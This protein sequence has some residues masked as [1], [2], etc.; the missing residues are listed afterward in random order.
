[1]S[2]PTASTASATA[3]SLLPE[4]GCA[5]LDGIQDGMSMMYELVAR[6]GQLSASTGEI[7]VS[8]Q[9]RAQ[10]TQAQREEAAIKQEEAD[11]AKLDTGGGLFGAICHIFSDIGKNLEHGRVLDVPVDATSDV[12]NMVDSPQFLAQ[13]EAIA[14]DVAEYVGVATA[15]V[16]AAALTTASCGSAGVAVAAVVVALSASGML[17]SKT[18]CFGKDSAYIGL[19]LEAAGAAVSLGASSALGVSAAAQAAEAAA[20]ATS[21]ASDVLAGASTV[22]VG[23][24]QADVLD[25]T[26]DVQQAT[27]LMNHATRLIADLVAGLQDAQKSN[28]NALQVIGGAVQTYNQSLT[29]A[30][31][32]KA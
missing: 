12:V 31:T 29:A 24:E 7:G 21:G 19:G 17:A 16:G 4:P 3:S 28:A 22:V 5:G 30:S 32:A 27:Q 20:D 15:V 26:A 11:E 23:N 6:Q 25:D 2:S 8:A 9:T 13:L 10:Q 14:P 18:H 1:V